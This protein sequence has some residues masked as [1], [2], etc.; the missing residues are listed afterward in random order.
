MKKRNLLFLCTGNSCRSQM[1][2]GYGRLFMGERYNVYSAGI[3]KHGLNPYMVKVMQEDGMDLSGHYSKTIT[4]LKDIDFDAV[5]TVCDDANETCPVYLKKT[6]L[7]HKGFEDPA[8]FQ[9]SEED[10]LNFFRKVRD[11]IKRYIKE[12]LAKEI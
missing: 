12:D 9:G 5:V 8:K 11:Q 6:R 1:A 4:E 3:E 2:E 10:K 7:I